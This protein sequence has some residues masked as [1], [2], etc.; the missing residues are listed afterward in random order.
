[1]N[2]RLET[3]IHMTFKGTDDWAP[4][5]VVGIE[6][7]KPE[8]ISIDMEKKLIVLKFHVIIEN[9]MNDE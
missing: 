1:M 2:E 9:G 3:D 4:G 8:I 7:Y 6:G 5:I